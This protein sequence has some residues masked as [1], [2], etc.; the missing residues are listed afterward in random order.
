MMMIAVW[1]STDTSAI[2]PA[3]PATVNVNILCSDGAT[4][5]QPVTERWMNKKLL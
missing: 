5:A 2:Q 4:C 1:A 3:K